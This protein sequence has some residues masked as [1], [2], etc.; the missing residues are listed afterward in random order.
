VR[1]L[2]RVEF[3]V[4]DQRCSGVGVVNSSADVPNYGELPMPETDKDSP[5][6]AAFDPVAP[7]KRIDS[8]DILRGFALLGVLWMNVPQHV[9]GPIDKIFD[10]MSNLLATGKFIT[11]FGFLF[12]VGFSLQW[13]RAT[14]HGRWPTVHSSRRLLVLFVIGAVHSVFV[15]DGDV[16]T[17][18]AL[19][20]V[21]LLVVQRLHLSQRTILTVALCILAVIAVRDEVGLTRRITRELGVATY[22]DITGTQLR[23]RLQRMADEEMQTYTTISYT[24]GVR[25]RW[26]GLR[27]WLRSR[28]TYIP[29]EVF[30]YFLLGL[31]AA[32]SGLF[33]DVRSHRRLLHRILWWGFPLGVALFLGKFV[34]SRLLYSGHN[35][36]LVDSVFRGGEMIGRPILGL[37]YVAAILLLLQHERWLHRLGP[38]RYVG[39]MALTNYLMQSLVFTVVS[40][41]FGFGLYARLTGVTALLYTVV[42]FTAQVYLSRWWLSRFRFGPVEWVWRSLTYG[43]LMPLRA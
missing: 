38:L 1:A 32:G 25:E 19:M 26:E 5:L 39:R 35:T 29:G 10:Q 42:F 2:G 12:G 43:V 34:S 6:K 37:T 14:A 22:V 4:G 33:R 21:Y 13:M 3:Q 20:G 28:E 23:E 7:E 11:I 24:Q 16:L 31:W 30:V 27:D 41:S 17:L 36:W 8:L 9:G 18:Y 15:W 40:Y